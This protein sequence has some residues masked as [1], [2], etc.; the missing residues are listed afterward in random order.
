MAKRSNKATSTEVEVQKKQN[1]NADCVVVALNRPQGIVFSLKN[2]RK[3]EIFGNAVHLRG[4][5]M[6][7][8]PM[9]GA[10]GLTPVSHADWKEIK[11]IYGD[12]ALFKSGRIFAAKNNRE[13]VVQAE[14]HAKTRHGLE[15]T[16]GQ[17]TGEIGREAVA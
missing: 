10:F 1:C 11:Q 8:L 6:G 16:K 15:P 17:V 12:T 2:G 7:V 4:K 9:G 5:E 3:V 14:D 13:A